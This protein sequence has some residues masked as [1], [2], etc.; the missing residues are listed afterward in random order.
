[1]EAKGMLEPEAHR[2]REGE[3]TL[4]HKEAKSELIWQN[5]KAKTGNELIR[6]G[7]VKESL[8]FPWHRADSD[9]EIVSWLRALEERK[10]MLAEMGRVAQRRKCFEEAEDRKEWHQDFI[11]GKTKGLVAKLTSEG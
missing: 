4:C 5:M 7:E 3:P 11:D 2:E 9:Q 10:G 6:L 8:E 1:M